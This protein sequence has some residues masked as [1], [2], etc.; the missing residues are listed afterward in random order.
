MRRLFSVLSRL[1]GSLATAL[2]EGESGVG[3]EIV[4]R[5]IHEGSSVARGPLVTLNCGALPR[6]LVASELF[7]H[8]KGAFTGAVE[9]RRGAFEAADHGTL[10]LDEIGELPLDVQPMLLRALE[11]GEVAVVGGSTPRRVQVRVVA[12]TNRDLESD[13]HDGRFR[14]DLFYRLAVV[15]LRVPPL[16][17]RLEDI[18]ALAERFGKDAGLEQVPAAILEELKSRPWP[19]NVRELRNTMQAYAALGVLPQGTRSK[20]ATLDLALR[21]MAD[22][23][24]PY[25][26]QKDAIVDRFTTAYLEVLMERTGG[27]Q[28]A[29]ARAAGLDRGYLGK[30]LQKHGLARKARGD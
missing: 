3:K 19:G 28:T 5:A 4:A 6:E 10:F 26:D 12:A 25:V 13:V 30:L 2:V 8:A 18:P 7:G 1:E 23:T 20:A 15:R 16:R 22:P 9:A 21:E 11:S 14:E 17:E 27:N 24:T 29:A